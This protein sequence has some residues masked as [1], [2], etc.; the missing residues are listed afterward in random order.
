[1]FLRLLLNVC[2]FFSSLQAASLNVPQAAQGIFQGLEDVHNILADRTEAEIKNTDKKMRR[3]EEE[4][5]KLCAL[6]DNGQIGTN[7]FEMQKKILED[8]IAAHK[9]SLA[10][11]EESCK[12]TATVAT[13]LFSTGFNAVVEIHKSKELAEAEINKAVG[14]AAAKQAVADKG[15]MARLQYLTNPEV[16]KSLVVYG[17][18]GALGISAAVYGSQLVINQIQRK[19]DKIPDLVRET[20]RTNLIQRIKKTLGDWWSGP[21]PAAQ[22]SEHFIFA[23]ET[24]AL[25]APIAERTGKLKSLGLPQ[26]GLFLYGPPGTGKTAFA[27]WLSY[28]TGMEYAIVSGSEIVKHPNSLAALIELIEWAKGCENGMILF[29]DEID[30]IAF[31]RSRNPDRNVVILL[32]ELLVLM[33]DEE[34]QRSCKFVGATNR[35]DDVD[36]AAMSRFAD[37]IAINLPG[38]AERIDLIN[39]YLNKYI[40]NKAHAIKQENVMKIVTLTVA[41]DVTSQVIEAIAELLP[42]ASGRTISQLVRQMQTEVLF[43]KD[44]ILTPAIMMQVA[45]RY[46]QQS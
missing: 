19:L 39:L 8:R 33:S 21:Q 42:N 2:V 27:K 45:E 13:Q 16:M 34:V 38:K 23:P 26:T 24:A 12:E 44:F 40:A 22:L 30:A 4:L 25:L 10:D 1:M 15:S 20:S 3:A 31:D 29:I 18:L 35:K 32:E 14:A 7:Q 43:S 46:A 37:Q 17:G 9:Q 6:R 11:I 41:P 5:I 28:N 36:S